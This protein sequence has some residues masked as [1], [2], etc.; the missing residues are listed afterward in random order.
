[1][2][3]RSEYLLTKRILTKAENKAVRASGKLALL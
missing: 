3:Q 1:M 2:A